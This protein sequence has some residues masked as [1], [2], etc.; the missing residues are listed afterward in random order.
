MN[1]LNISQFFQSPLNT[2]ACASNYTGVWVNTA[3][4]L[5]S[6]REAR[7]IIFQLQPHYRNII[8]FFHRTELLDKIVR[9]SGITAICVMSGQGYPGC[10]KWH[11]SWMGCTERP[12]VIQ[13]Q[14]SSWPLLF[15]FL[16]RW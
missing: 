6:V 4:S 12:P 8:K 15:V 11:I 5:I 3:K 14:P 7:F 9:K 13:V 10:K 16:L 1:L 2:V